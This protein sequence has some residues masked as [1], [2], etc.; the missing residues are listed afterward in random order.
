[1]TT[2]INFK[3]D[4]R[5]VKAFKDLD[6]LNKLENQKILEIKKF[7]GKEEDLPISTNHTTTT[8][9]KSLKY[10]F[11]AHFLIDIIFAAPLLI[12]PIWFLQT[13]NFEASAGGV[14]SLLARL[15]GAALLGIGGASFTM[16]N[17]NV[18]AYTSMLQLKLLWSGSAIIGIS[19]FLLETWSTIGAGLLCIFLVFFAVWANFL[20]RIKKSEKKKKKKRKE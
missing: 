7:R 5:K 16:R 10:W 15:V 14:E 6:S 8:M 11:L 1:M 13:L 12:A 20:S 3:T 19:L 17:S 2:V 9:P 18:S 4:S